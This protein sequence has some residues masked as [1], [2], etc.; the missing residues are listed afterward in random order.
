[1]TENNSNSIPKQFLKCP[2]CPCVFITE[3]DLQKHLTCM[4]EHKEEHIDVYR[5]A[6]GRI[7]RGFGNAE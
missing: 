1:M 2:H 7:E 3:A 4:G 5:R 6:H